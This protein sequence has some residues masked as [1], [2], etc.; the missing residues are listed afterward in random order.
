MRSHPSAARTKA[1]RLWLLSAA[2]LMALF[3]WVST[4]AALPF[5]GAETAVAQLDHG[6]H[7]SMHE[8]CCGAAEDIDCEPCGMA[9]VCSFC[10]PL[11]AA[12]RD[13]G[14]PGPE[15]LAPGPALRQTG[16]MVLPPDHPPRFP[17]LV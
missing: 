9:S 11:G 8:D 12:L 13:R 4:A 3:T 15:R 14:I 7:P 17:A 10:A 2:L 16:L 6:P 5:P 1:E